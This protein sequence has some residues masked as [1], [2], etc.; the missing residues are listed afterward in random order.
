MAA[1]TATATAVDNVP[2]HQRILHGSAQHPPA[3]WPAS[4]TTAA[5]RIDAKGIAKEIVDSINY[6][7]SVTKD[8][9][10]IASLFR[11]GGPSSDDN[12]FW[13]DHLA[14]SWGLR[15]L[16]GATKIGDFLR[17]NGKNLIKVEVD[18]SSAWKSPQ[19]ANFAPAGEVKGVGFYINFESVR[20]KGRGVV[21]L[22]QERREEEQESVGGGAWRIWTIFTTL[23]GLNGF[24]EPLGGLRSEGVKHGGMVGRKN[25]SEM[26][27][28]EVEFAEGK[29]PEVLVIGEY[30][31]LR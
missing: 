4:A 1:A 20:G 30:T 17:E 7:L 26:R 18:D 12:A 2:S 19:V 6:A 3:P 15:T 25:W 16:K 5:E 27:E 31:I 21:R 9:A 8:Y 11:G 29:G 10:T 24:E 23:E 22:V 14:L 28:E 13:R